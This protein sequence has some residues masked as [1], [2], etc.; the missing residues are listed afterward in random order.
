MDWITFI[1]G[2][3]SAIY[4]LLAWIHLLAP[5]I[6]RGQRWHLM[7]VGSAISAGALS[8][9]E[10][11]AIKFVYTSHQYTRMLFYGQ[12]AFGGIIIMT[13]W[14]VTLY[15]RAGRRWLAWLVTAMR[16]LILVINFFSLS[17]FGYVRID[18]LVRIKF[19]N[20]SFPVPIVSLS[21]WA[22]FGNLS[23]VLFFIFCVD[24][25]WSVWRRGER[26]VAALVGASNCLFGLLVAV[27]VILFRV[28]IGAHPDDVDSYLG[29]WIPLLTLPLYSVYFLGVAMAMSYELSSEMIRAASLASELLEN[30]R[31]LS[32]AVEAAEIEISIYDFRNDRLW[33]SPSIRNYVGIAPEAEVRLQDLLDR[34][35]A[36]DRKLLVRAIAETR[37]K[38]SPFSSEYRVSLGEGR[39]LWIAS[40]GE[41]ERS[42]R[43]EPL[44]LR[45]VSLD[46]TDRKKLEESAINLSR[47]LLRAQEEERARVARDLNDDLSQG[48]ALHSI[49][50]GLL[51][52]HPPADPDS[53][54][55]RISELSGR[56]SAI[57]SHVHR[58]SHDLHP[59]KLRR[60]GLEAA[61]R[62]FCRD[63]SD[64][65]QMAISF[66]RLGIPQPVSDDVALC[67]Y[68]VTQES[69]R[70]VVRHSQA[71]TASVELIGNGDEIRLCVSD[72]GCGFNPEL[73]I[74]GPT[75]G[76]IS[77][78]ERVHL[79]GGRFSIDSQPEGGTIVTVTIPLPLKVDSPA[80][81]SGGPDGDNSA[82]HSQ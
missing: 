68:R 33:L 79:L 46:I 5:L 50:L 39:V 51:G 11:Y 9:F 55:R 73:A 2:S 31:R 59:A 42:P 81:V 23:L 36:E 64:S 20:S 75:L 74:S 57:S 35:Q 15:C 76:I 7:F 25:T 6:L 82:P 29:S 47:M 60:I 77:M 48:L 72:D 12:L 41:V 53:F 1:W 71:S 19:L 80:V 63:F 56:I 14:F 26:R 62:G 54:A 61:I 65:Q 13:T 66:V 44:F 67:L 22:M 58:I 28:T 17:S 10:L 38:G 8:C 70:N 40:M 32:L 16:G 52:R 24:V 45:C 3:L 69:L 49:E 34:V 27:Q 21:P 30:E 43:G 18:S 78:R 37:D 4:F